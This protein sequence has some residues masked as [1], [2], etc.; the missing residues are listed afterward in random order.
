MFNTGERNKALQKVINF[1]FYSYLLPLH[2]VICAAKR[3]G[4][5]L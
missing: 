1:K 4:S 5:L 2:G 3:G